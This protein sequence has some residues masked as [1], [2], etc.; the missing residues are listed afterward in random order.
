MLLLYKLDSIAGDA[1]MRCVC[2]C[3]CERARACVCVGGG[4][5]VHGLVDGWVGQV[6]KNHRER[7]QG[8]HEATTSQPASRVCCSRTHYEY[9]AWL[10]ILQYVR[11]GQ[12]NMLHGLLGEGS[13]RSTVASYKLQSGDEHDTKAS[14]AAHNPFTPT[15]QRDAQLES[16]FPNILPFLDNFSFICHNSLPHSGAVSLMYTYSSLHLIA[17]PAFLLSPNE[18]AAFYFVISV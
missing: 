10:Q 13:N 7:T 17:W 15:D 14:M 5:R 2:V 6:G 11:T 4:V 9:G 8:T 18:A 12:G 1:V 16:P 3:V